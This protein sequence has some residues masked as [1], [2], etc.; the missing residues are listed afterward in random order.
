MN[1]TLGNDKTF[2]CRKN[3][4][5]TN[6]S[7]NKSNIIHPVSYIWWGDFYEEDKCPKSA[8]RG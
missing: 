7:R 4:T 8:K 1:K 2:C 5:R 3:C 6:C